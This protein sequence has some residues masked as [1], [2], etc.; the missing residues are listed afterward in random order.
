MQHCVHSVD[1]INRCGSI[2]LTCAPQ[3]YNNFPFPLRAQFHSAPPYYILK[4]SSHNFARL[5]FDSVYGV[6][7]I[8]AIKDHTYPDRN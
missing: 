8:S 7:I 6:K 4:Q 3:L 2:E 5:Q 1:W